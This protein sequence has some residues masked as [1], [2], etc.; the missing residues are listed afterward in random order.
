MARLNV[1]KNFANYMNRTGYSS[2]VSTTFMSRNS[3]IVRYGCIQFVK[4][5]SSSE[6]HEV[7]VELSEK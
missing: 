7:D 5:F 1:Y 6:A 2:S 3:Y 4:R